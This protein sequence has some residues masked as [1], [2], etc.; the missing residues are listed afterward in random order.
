MVFI[1]S[2][3]VNIA[4]PVI[5]SDLDASGSGL[6]WIMD[7][8]LLTLSSLMLAGGSLGD[9]LGRNKVFSAGLILFSFSSVSC[10]LSF[11]STQLIISRLFQGIGGALLTPGSLSI[12]ITQFSGKKV[13]RAIGLWS[14][15]T[16]LTSVAGPLLGGWLAAP[17]LWRII[18]F[19]NI[20]LSVLAFWMITR[21][22]PES[23]NSSATK[24]DYT[25]A[26]FIILG[27]SGLAYGFI[28]SSEKGFGH[29][30]IILALSAGFVFLLAFMKTEMT[31]KG[32]LVPSG[33]FRSVHFST[34]NGITL[35]LYGALSGL[36]FFLPLNLVQVQ[37]YSEWQGGL[38]FF[39]IV[40]L[41]ACLSPLMGRLIESFGSRVFLIA[42]P[43]ITGAGF[44]VY[45]TIGQTAGPQDYWNT[46]LL[47]SLLVGAGMGITVVPLTT[48]VM[49]SVDR[50]NSGTASGINNS[51]SRIAGLMAIALMG[52]FAIHHFRNAVG[53]KIN[54]L[55][56]NLE[57]KLQLTGNTSDFAATQIPEGISGF[58]KDRVRQIIHSSFI[59]SFDQVTHISALASWLST[60]LAFIFIKKRKKKT[61]DNSP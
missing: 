25:G 23:R 21:K 47:P 42:G 59:E 32:P 10:G 6:L 51:V 43:F 12:I 5:Q 54:A 58:Q 60:L 52:T 26:A 33:L 19:I 17:G 30:P 9:S 22:V 14:T 53:E 31:V 48:T 27:L 34:S 49:R 35:F 3:T 38:V 29:A 56:I 41:I 20:P 28:Q 45:G 44:F 40:L 46:F 15:F 24:L 36:T 37:G 55:E 16:S 50:K 13:G 61:T 2:T 4:L 18:F 7:A 57:Q 1:D 39:P 11:S 8:Y